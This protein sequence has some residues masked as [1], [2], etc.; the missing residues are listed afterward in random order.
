ME[1]AATPGTAR[2]AALLEGGMPVAIIRRTLLRILQDL[3][4]L[5]DF[6]EHLFRL[7]VAGILVRVKLHGLFTIG[8]LQVILRHALDYAEQ[9]VVILFLSGSHGLCFG[10][11]RATTGHHDGGRAQQ[12][13][14]QTVTETHH[15]H[16][17]LFGDLSGRLM[18]NTLVK[19]WVEALTRGIDLL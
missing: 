10:F 17:M 1:P 9:V 15:L 2:T 18:G 4:G 8:L 16:H 14:V 11:F 7:L 3:V 5:G 6:L 13:P 12:P 19:M